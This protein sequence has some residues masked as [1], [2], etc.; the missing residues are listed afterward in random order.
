MCWV[1][2]QQ[3]RLNSRAVALDT[4]NNAWQMADRA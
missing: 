3:A 1:I 4:R 2:V